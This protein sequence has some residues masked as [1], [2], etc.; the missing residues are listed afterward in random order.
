MTL[1]LSEIQLTCVVESPQSESEFTYV[2][3][4]NFLRINV[5][6]AVFSEM[7]YRPVQALGCNAPLIQF[8]ILALYIYI[9]I[10]NNNN[11]RLTAFD[12]GQ[13]G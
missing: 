4:W 3:A 13:P 12:P 2:N 10:Y 1:V 6:N 7:S 9:Y 8:L 5:H 11:D